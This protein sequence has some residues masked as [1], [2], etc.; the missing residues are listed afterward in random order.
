MEIL[1]QMCGNADRHCE[2]EATCCSYASGGNDILEL[3]T[4]ENIYDTYANC[5]GRQSCT[6][7]QAHWQLLQAT[8]SNGDLIFSSFVKLEYDCEEGSFIYQCTEINTF[9]IFSNCRK[10]PQ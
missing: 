4:L 7:I 1:F 10:K 6:K 5:S 2:L 3:L 8:D 9:K